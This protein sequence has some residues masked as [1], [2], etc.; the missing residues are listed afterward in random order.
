MR[1]D[2]NIHVFI[3]SFRNN[4]DTRKLNKIINNQ[5]N[6]NKM[7]QKQIEK[8]MDTIL[9]EILLVDCSED[10][11]RAIISNELDKKNIFDVNLEDEIL[12]NWKIINN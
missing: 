6:K 1:N 9:Q 12:E 5:K 3:Y 2:N 4:N 8:L 7:K 10:D 11:V